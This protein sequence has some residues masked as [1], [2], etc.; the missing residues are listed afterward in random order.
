L[1][2]TGVAPSRVELEITEEVL[3]G[4]NKETLATL[5]ELRKLGIKIVMDDFGIG[6]SSLNYLR[7]FPFDKIKID[8]SFVNDLSGGN[9][10]PF[11]IVQAVS[12]LARALNIP[13]T[14]E[15]IETSE[16]LELLRTAGCTEFQGHLFSRPTS[17][18][19]IARLVAVERRVETNAA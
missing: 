6:Y 10:L 12:R 13:T 19:D 2:E 8:R 9:D 17:A 5:N 16:Q 14:A 15:G 7:L 18:A 11:V 1:T 4:H 3:L